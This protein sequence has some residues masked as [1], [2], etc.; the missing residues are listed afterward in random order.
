MKRAICIILSLI[1]GIYCAN[2]GDLKL[3]TVVIDAGHGGK[4]A[5]AVSKDKKTFEKTLTLDISKRFATLIQRAYPEVKVVLTRETDDFVA[6]NERAVRANKAG[7]NVFIS[8]HINS[9]TSTT[10]NGYSVHILGQSSVKDRDLF[11]YN[12]DVCKRENSVILLEDDYNAKYQ[13]FDPNDEESYIFMQLMQNAH[14]EQSLLLASVISEKLKGGPIK[15]DRGI[16]QNP[17]YVLW[18]TAM[19][20]V[21]V[22]IGFISNS[23]DLATLR[24]PEQ[25]QIIAKRLFEAFKDYK[26][27]Y[28]SSVDIK[29]PEKPEEPK[30]QIVEQPKPA[31]APAPTP[32]PAPEAKPQ[33]KPQQ[34]A[35]Q[36]KPAPA[37]AAKPAPEAKPQPK[38]QQT[39]Q[40][41]KPQGKVLYGTQIS[42][43]TRALDPSDRFF[44]GLKPM[45]IKTGSLNKYIAGL[46]ESREEAKAKFDEIRSKYPND[47]KDSF[48]VVVQDGTVSRLR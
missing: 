28:D 18:K 3:T 5:G 39:A 25:R 48:M 1:I 36:P 6:L 20:A 14:L 35:Q 15:A 31:P 47:Y 44:H 7:A 4:D 30:P 34:T 12:M 24:T 43:S 23:V 9:A 13:G 10:P 38:P 8:I 26:D 42:A 37:A 19:P 32:K 46:S 27:L 22:E 21:L 2:A 45:V 40:Q 33:P 11:A 41:P 17:F 16:W 29:A